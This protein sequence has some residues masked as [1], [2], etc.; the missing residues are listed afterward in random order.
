MTRYV[1]AST[2]A[3][4]PAWV[5]LVRALVVVALV[6][7][8]GGSTYLVFAPLPAIASEEAVVASP[9]AGTA[10]VTWPATGSAAFAIPGIEG[11]SGAT[12]DAAVPMASIT[13]LATMLVV[14]EERPI[15]ANGGAELTMDAEDVAFMQAAFDEAAPYVP[16]R[17]GQTVSQADL[18]EASVVASSANA[19]MTLARWAFG[20]TEAF[21][22]AAND[23]AER[24]GLSTMVVADAAGLSLAS[25]A[26]PADMVRLGELALAD[27]IV[28]AAMGQRSVSVTGLGAQPNTNPLLGV[29]G[30]DAGKTGALFVSG[31]NLLVSATAT[32]DG[33]SLR[34]VVVV[35][36]QVSEDDRDAA[37]IGLV[38]SLWQNVQTR[39]LLPAGAVVATSTA[40]WGPTSQA[41]ADAALT[42]LA[43]VAQPL[44]LVI[45]VEP[46]RTGV[47]SMQVGTVAVAGTELSTTVTAR[48]LA[49][50]DL[51]W[52]LSNPLVLL[53][54][55]DA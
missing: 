22:Q 21:L 17:T 16:V 18:V 31:R 53:G 4:T 5:H 43:W 27:P 45:D 29:S 3:R 48:R 51:L 24:N 30:I 54:L 8:V 9:T 42:S 46:V 2:Q 49:E 7:L 1:T 55:A 44:E 34:A 50:P 14:L 39:E 12:S 47:G 11:A 28:G 52:R 38:D 33:R 20:S 32:V 25:V 19:A 15:A 35:A 10:Q 26:S 36:G 23:W 6:A 13:K 40:A 37:T 41:T